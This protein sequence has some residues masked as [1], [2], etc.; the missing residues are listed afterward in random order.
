MARFF[1]TLSSFATRGALVVLVTVLGGF[2]LSGWAQQNE[3]GRVTGRVIDAE[4]EAPLEGATVALWQKEA[5]DSTLV[6]GTT[7]GPDGR[8]A[9]R[10]L[11][12]A[13]LTV[14]VSY[15]GYTDREY[16]DTRPTTQ[17]TD[18][19][20][21]RLS[22]EPTQAERVEV[23]ADR[24]AA[25]LETDRTVYNTSER[26]ISAGGSAETILSTLPSLQIDADGSISY[27]GNESVAIYINGDPASLAGESLLGY[28]RSLPAE[29][30]EQIEIIS[31]P[32]AR[33]EPEGTAGIINVVLDR[34][35]DA[36]WGGGVTV[37]SQRTTNGR[38]GGNGSANASYQSGGW[39]LVATYSHDR[40][41]EEDTDARF[42]RRFNGGATDT[43]ITQNGFEEEAERSHALNTQVDYSPTENT[44]V[45]LEATLSVRRDEEEGRTETVWTGAADSTN[46]RLQ[47]NSSGD[48]TID[49]RLSVDHDFGEDHTL[50]TEVRY[51]RDFESEDATYRNYR[52]LSGS[53]LG[54]RRVTEFETVGED[55]QD[56]SVE[57]DYA[58]PLGSLSLETGYKGTL[59]RLDSDQTYE[60]QGETERRDF[61]FDEHIHA[62]YGILSK[63]L[64]LFAL[65]AGLRAETVTTDVNPVGEPAVES[66]Y[67]SLYPSVFLTYEPNRRRQ[68]RLSYSKR[69]DRP[70][71]WDINPIEDNENP[72]FV[73]RG[74]P[75][76][77]PE[78]IHSVELSATQRWDAAS[79]TLTPYVRRTVNEIE[80]VEFEEQIDGRTVT[81]R[82]ARNFSSSMSYGTELITTFDIGDRLEGT[83]SG[84]VYRSVTDGSNLTTDLSNNA[85]TVSGQAN[86]RA[87]LHDGLSLEVSQFYRPAQDIPGGRMDR[88]TSTEAALQQ[89]LFSGGGSL[90]LRVDDLFDATSVN[91]QRRTNNFFQETTSQW[92][93]REVSL[94][95][96]YTFGGG[97]RGG[98]DRKDRDYD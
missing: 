17:G 61:T 72:S 36:G 70:N 16:P 44:T 91:V 57:V 78:Y 92:G 6:D 50:S 19:G 90:T 96:Q 65:E 67:N 77:D 29:A 95:F 73:E 83:V 63:E 40:E 30:I 56:G 5:G 47:D 11:P 37:G 26:A 62:V 34:G 31:N 85:L 45:G 76:L 68:V 23:T 38:Y 21:L 28:L 42:V 89:Q 2:P 97:E 69:V 64:G 20:T 41:G 55:E 43:E 15:V 10:G 13:P 82:Q 35:V 14:W 22:S 27:R 75:T 24:P 66:S 71:L 46:A 9:I 51:D 8:F 79:V 33:Y 39:R 87:Q 60:E 49:G 3:E 1:G 84:N 25:R 86:V 52:L 7:T 88:I 80:E 53:G 59:R 94:S 18:L 81:V 12:T 58:R 98:R 48:E 4:T 74:N 93:A 32:S 54:A